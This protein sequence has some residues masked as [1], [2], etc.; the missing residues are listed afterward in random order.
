MKKQI[1]LRTWMLIM[2]FGLI[3][4]TC[5]SCSQGDP[6]IQVQYETR[7]MKNSTKKIT[8]SIGSKTFTAALLDNEAANS[9]FDLLPLTVTMTELN[10]NEKYYRLPKNLPTNPATPG[11][12][13]SG[14]LMLWGA[15]TVVIFY[16]TFDTSYSYTRLGKIDDPDGLKAALGAGNVS[17]SFSK[18]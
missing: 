15:N 16:E 10:R 17:V 9:F 2:I 18:E 14:D 1:I 6:S 7:D 11:T 13:L 5:Y 3:S 12:I 4:G 8:I